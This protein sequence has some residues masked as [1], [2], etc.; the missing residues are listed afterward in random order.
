MAEEIFRLAW[1]AF[2]IT[3]AVAASA[4]VAALAWLAVVTMLDFARI[5]WRSW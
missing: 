4:F 5:A 2:G 1:Y 3:C